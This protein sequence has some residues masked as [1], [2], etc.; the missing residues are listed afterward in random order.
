[1]VGVLTGRSSV[2]SDLFLPSY[3][4]N[5][6]CVVQVSDGA[7]GL[8][9]AVTVGVTVDAKSR[10]R[11]RS[12]R[13]KNAHPAGMWRSFFSRLWPSVF[14]SLTCYLGRGLRFVRPNSS[15]AFCYASF[16]FR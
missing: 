11:D 14:R 4:P 8:R 6:L 13:G 12:L 15:E 3:L 1:M 16:G 7:L 2:E 10:A 9:R 5:S